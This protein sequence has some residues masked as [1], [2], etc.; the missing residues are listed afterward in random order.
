[1]FLDWDKNTKRLIQWLVSFDNYNIAM[2][3]PWSD[4]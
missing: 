4:T 3:P 1:M 2:N